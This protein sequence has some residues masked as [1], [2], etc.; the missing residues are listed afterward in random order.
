MKTAV[1]IAYCQLFG[2]LISAKKLTKKT[3]SDRQMD[4]PTDR[5]M[6]SG[7][8]SNPMT[9]PPFFQKL[10]GFLLK[11]SDSSSAA[12][13][14]ASAA[15]ATIGFPGNAA[16]LPARKRWFVFNETTCRLY[17]YKNPNDLDALGK[18]SIGKF[19]KTLIMEKCLVNPSCLDMRLPTEES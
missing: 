8:L 11:Q 18:W 5:P 17:W 19:K 15:A 4:R 1:S 13:K 6:Q 3:F 9:S 7:V 14:A 2:F 10:C 16:R 12:S